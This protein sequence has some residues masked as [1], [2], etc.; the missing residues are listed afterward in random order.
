MAFEKLTPLTESEAAHAFS[1]TPV[2]DPQGTSTPE[3]LAAAGQA[4]ELSAAGGSAVFVVTKK[5]AQLWIEAAAGH[6][7]D[8]LTAVGLELIEEM[9]RQAG[10]TEV[11]FQTARPGLVKK[12]N[13][14]G[15]Q[16]AGWILKKAV[17]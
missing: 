2:P 12:A 15:Y 11:G 9:A 8:D 10:C 5:G 13:Q 16:V 17:I 14:R 3:T 1:V 7:A 4:F 6:A